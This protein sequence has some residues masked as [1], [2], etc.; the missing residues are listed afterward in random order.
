MQLLCV[1]NNSLS[2]VLTFRIVFAQKNYK[3]DNKTSQPYY[4]HQKHDAF[5]PVLTG[6]FFAPKIPLTH[7]DNK[8]IFNLKMF[9]YQNVSLECP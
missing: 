2:T 8:N 5:R 3:Y 1:L 6:G 9:M 4:F 7:I